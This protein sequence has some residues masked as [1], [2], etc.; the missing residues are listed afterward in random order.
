[1]N[2]GARDRLNHL[3]IQILDQT[4]VAGCHEWLAA[5]PFD[6]ADAWDRTAKQDFNST[7]P[8][9][10][11]NVNYDY[12]NSDFEYGIWD[13]VATCPNLESLGIEATQYLDLTLFTFGENP[14]QLPLHVL[15]L[16]RI[17][18]TVS[19]LLQLRTRG[20]QL[21][22]HWEYP[23]WPLQ[24]LSLK[25]VKI[26]EYGG[27]WSE[28][29]DFLNDY[30]P[31]LEAVCL[32]LLTYFYDHENNT[33]PCSEARGDVIRSYCSLVISALLDLLERLADETGGIENCTEHF[34]FVV[35]E[36]TK[37]ME[38]NERMERTLL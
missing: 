13:F 37:I 23:E 38:R 8:Y 32:H 17:Y 35:H 20:T 4:G 19:S 26:H 21:L 6:D 24:R 34:V 16:S 33:A 2:E 14:A 9:P 5:I 31:N 29:F 22:P 27:E 18:V 25:D 3:Y 12:P 7:T 11:S 1:M 36:A 28:V 10:F 30:C 15:T